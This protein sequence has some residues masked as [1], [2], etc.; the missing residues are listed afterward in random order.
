MPRWHWDGYYYSPYSGF[1]FKF[2]TVLKGNPTLFYQLPKDLRKFFEQHSD[3]R[4]FLSRL[5]ER[6]NI[7]TARSGQGAF[8]IVGDSDKAAA[9]SKPKIDSERLFF[10]ILPGNEGEINKLYAR[11]NL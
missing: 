10:S 2:A 1:I 11:W 4:E 6:K 3:D 5:L 9:H 8:F 7:E